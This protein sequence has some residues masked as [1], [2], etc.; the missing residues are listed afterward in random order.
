MRAVFLKFRH[1]NGARFPALNFGFASKAFL[2]SQKAQQNC[3]LFAWWHSLI[4]DLVSPSLKERRKGGGE[5]TKFF[6]NFVPPSSRNCTPPL[7]FPPFSATQ[8]PPPIGLA[9]ERE[10]ITLLLFLLPSNPAGR[11]TQHSSTA[12]QFIPRDAEKRGSF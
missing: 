9:R 12:A 5:E 1:R 11:E 6:S 8:F 3:A 2:D 10:K 4:R 7:E